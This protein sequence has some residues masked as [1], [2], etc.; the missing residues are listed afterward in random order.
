LSAGLL[1]GQQTDEHRTELPSSDTMPTPADLIPSS[2][3]LGA[4][5]QD[6]PSTTVKQQVTV[7]RELLD[8]L[9]RPAPE[10]FTFGRES[11]DPKQFWEGVVVARNDDTFTARVVDRTNPSNA[12]EIVEIGSDEVTADDWN[13]VRPGASFYWS[14][15]FDRSAAGTITKYSDIRFRRLPGWTRAS[16]ADAQR[17]ADVLAALFADR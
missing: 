11:R 17:E 12:D 7:G 5:S 4:V 1:I 15:G 16:L 2:R 10:K 13:L 8:V 14:I 9:V 6:V 3:E